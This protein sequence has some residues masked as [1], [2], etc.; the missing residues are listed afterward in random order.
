MSMTAREDVPIPSEVNEFLENNSRTFLFTLRKDGWPT[1]HPMVGFYKQG[2]L[3]FSTYRKS[4]K[5]RNVERD[6]RI[7]CLVT[8][9]HDDPDFRA[10]VLRGRGRVQE[11]E[12]KED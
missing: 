8:T 5:T 10:V 11:A 2:R 12:K 3:S 7:A 9:R 6:D 1:A 4:V